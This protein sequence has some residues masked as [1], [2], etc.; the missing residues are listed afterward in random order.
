[1]IDRSATLRLLAEGDI[2]VVG[3][4]IGSSNNA[5]FVRVTRPC[6]DPEPSDAIDAVYKPTIGERP[7]DDFP[8]GTLTRREV[9]A[10][11]A[12][13][14]IGWDI[15]PPTVLRDGP[16]GEGMVQA[17]IEADPDVDVVAMV[18]EDDPRLRRM[19]VFDA[20]IN[21]T[22]RKGGHILPVDGGRH[23]HGVDHGV[24]FSVVPKLRTVL[25]GWRGEPLA[26]DET[27]GLERL[28]DALAAD[29]GD[30]LRGL[31][32]AAEVRATERRVAALLESRRFPLPSPTW[33][34]IPWPP[35]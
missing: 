22:D 21:N 10:W 31:L 6:P 11:E 26:P 2:E 18:V 15:V 28:A 32:S 29:L 5:L 20:A 1:M 12:S 33:P 35:F 24:T 7:L 27:A 9:A 4:I 3:R 25:W 19:A 8:E 17:F 34:A 23:V 30:A 14:A 13:Q 16:F